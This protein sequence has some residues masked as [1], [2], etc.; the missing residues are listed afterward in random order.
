MASTKVIY[1]TLRPSDMYSVDIFLCIFN[2]TGLEVTDNYYQNILQRN[3]FWSAFV[4]NRLRDKIN[5]KDWVDHQAVALVNAFYHPEIN[6]MIF[7]AGIL[8]GTFF[9]SKVPKYMNFGAIG[10]IVGHEITHGFDNIGRQHD[11]EGQ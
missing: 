1:F 2:F 4:Y 3:K 11:K 8:Q 7:P 5:P 6:A 9:N 10:S